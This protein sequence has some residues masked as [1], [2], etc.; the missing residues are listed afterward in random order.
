L[1]VSA[2][3]LICADISLISKCI[4]YREKK[5]LKMAE[6]LFNKNKSLK[7]V[8]KSHHAAYRESSKIETFY[9]NYVSTIIAVKIALVYI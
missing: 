5:S 1:Q 2:N 3:S 6:F 4:D 9:T 7:T 8:N